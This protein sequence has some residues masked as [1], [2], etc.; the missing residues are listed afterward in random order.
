MPK[1][2]LPLLLLA[3]ITT[4][5]AEPPPLEVETD[6]DVLRKVG[7]LVKSTLHEDTAE[8]EKGW[9]GLKDMGNLAVPGLVGL[10]RQSTTTPEMT[11]SI[12]IALEDS[13]D[14]RA[15]PALVEILASKDAGV[16]R[17]AARAIG[18]SNYKAAVPALEK[19]AGD[20][21]E[22]EEVRLFAAAAGAKLGG[23]KSI[24]ILQELQKS[25]KTEIRSRATFAL[26]KAGGK[27]Q[28]PAIEKGLS[29]SDSSVREDAV[30]ALRLI[31]G[32]EVLPG[33]VK[34]LDD[35]DHRVRGAAMDALRQVTKQKIENDP[36]AWR[37]WWKKKQG[38][39][40]KPEEK[41]KPEDGKKPL[42]EETK[43]KIKEMKQQKKQ[44]LVD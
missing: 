22:D 3:A 19:L 40:A 31:G 24:A 35:E 32:E 26:G 4:G 27:Q 11:R 33:L 2:F 6:P 7:K 16:R 28:I 17:D 23:E 13:K 34:A 42:P 9:K 21:N 36:A 25:S 18:D 29:D 37:E 8:R 15:G 41:A 1:Y 43:E 38:G 5:A 10:Y 14:A 12:L 44:E 39:D 20:A 30:E